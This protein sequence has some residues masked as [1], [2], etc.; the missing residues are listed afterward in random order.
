MS[1]VMTLDLDFGFVLKPILSLTKPALL[2]CRSCDSATFKHIGHL[3]SFLFVNLHNLIL[4]L[5]F[6]CRTESSEKVLAV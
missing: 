1:Y 4:T 6:I 5:G 2:Q 3:A